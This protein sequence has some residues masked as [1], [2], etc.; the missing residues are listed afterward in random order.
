[1]TPVE[2]ITVTL[3]VASAPSCPFANTQADTVPLQAQS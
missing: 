1:M 3:E 2:K